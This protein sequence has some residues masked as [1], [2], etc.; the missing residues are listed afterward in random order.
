MQNCHLE[1]TQIAS[2]MALNARD[3]KI[4]STLELPICKSAYP[5]D[6]TPCPDFIHSMSGFI[7]ALLRTLR[8]I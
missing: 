2:L 4:F 6:F 5:A 7:K 3:R 1:A 8:W